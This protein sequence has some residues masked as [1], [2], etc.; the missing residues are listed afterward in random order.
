MLI[1]R[2]RCDSTK[3]AVV[4]NVNTL[5]ATRSNCSSPRCVVRCNQ[6]PHTHAHCVHYAGCWFTEHAHHT[7]PAV[8]HKH[9][10][11]CRHQHVIIHALPL[12]HHTRSISSLVQSNVCVT[13]RF[14]TAASTSQ[15]HAVAKA[16]A[17]ASAHH[18][19]SSTPTSW[20]PGRLPLQEQQHVWPT[21][22]VASW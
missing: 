4:N 18:L 12:M 17:I 2:T 21:A 11:L 16:L 6:H 3:I 22:A 10:P 7:T 1:S 20:Q 5:Q 15:Q 14:A 19:V 8:D 13:W 9:F